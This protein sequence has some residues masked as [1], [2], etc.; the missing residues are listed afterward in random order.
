M[1]VVR[2]RDPNKCFE[3]CPLLFWTI[4]YVASRRYAKSASLVP[5][6]SEEI[7]RQV[8]AALG[9]SPL[10]L[11]TMNAIILVC[12]WVFPRARFT[13]DPAAVLSTA[14]ANAALLLGIHTGRGGHPEYSHGA[15]QNNYTDEAATY[16][17]AGLN[18]VSQRYYQQ[19]ATRI[20][21]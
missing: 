2:Q 18:I 21:D 17:W 4:I 11:F 3:S 7:R 13:S 14:T 19:P 16:T 10:T 9:E 1:P 5:F 20:S 15:F 12:T 8:F 6:L